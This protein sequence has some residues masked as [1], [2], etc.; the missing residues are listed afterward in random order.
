MRLFVA[1]P[2]APVVIGELSAASAR[3]QSK[4]DGLRWSA[5]ESWHITLQFLGNTGQQQYECML[6]RLRQ[7]RTAPVPIVME[8][9]G[10]FDRAGILF[11]G[12]RL[13]PE[14]LLLQQRVTAA[15]QPCGFVP[16]AR[17]YQPHITLARSKGQGLGELK[18]KML[19]QPKL[20][21]FVAEEFLLYESFLGSTG[22][23]YEVRERFCLNAR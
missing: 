11:A 21:K 16:E 5:P 17:T 19:Q 15:T 2:L 6:A 12:V 14:L 8:G 9:L 22:S 23:R 3:L 1:V 13:T 20:S 7:L 4:G 18:N 10:C